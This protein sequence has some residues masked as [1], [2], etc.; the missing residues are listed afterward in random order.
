MELNEDKLIIKCPN[1]SKRLTLK[2]KPGAELERKSLTCPA[3]REVSPFSSYVILQKNSA[4]SARQGESTKMEDAGRTQIVSN[5]A[6]SDDSTRLGSD[7]T[8]ATPGRFIAVAGNL[9]PMSLK[10]GRNILGRENSSSAVD[11]AL[12]AQY[13]YVSRQ[14]LIIDVKR[15]SLGY[16]HTAML[17]KSEVNKTYVNSMQL[18][19]GDQV[20]LNDGDIVKFP[21]I[22]LRFE[23]K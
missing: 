5:N 11:I 17:S 19:Y 4:Q 6:G 22:S 18:A 13:K 10:E 3:C 12:P 8:I 9:A 16:T 23:L 2:M 14:H 1:C 15:T 20:I 21:D 7:N